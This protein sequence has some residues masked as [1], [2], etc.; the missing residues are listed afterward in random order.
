MNDTGV[1]PTSTSFQN[2]GINPRI[3]DIVTRMNFTS[4]TPIQHQAIPPALSGKDVVG[5]AQT[6]TG[7][8]LAF[9]IPMLQSILEKGGRGLVILPTRELAHQVDETLRKFGPALGIESAVFIG[10]A[11]MYQQKQMLKRN[12]KIL[13][14]TPG[15]LMDHLQ[16]GTVTLREVNILVLDEADRMFDMG[17]APA[18]QRIIKQIP[19]ERQTMLFSAT[20]PH[21]I[22][23]LA[24]AHMKMPL[25]IEVAPQG[26]T[27]DRVE[28]ELIMVRKEEKIRLLESILGTVKGT[29]LVFS[30]TKHGAKKIARSVK[31]MGHTVSELHANKSLN[32]RKEALEGFKRGRY[33]VLIATDIAAR[34]IDVKE[35]ELV[36]NYDLPDNPEDYVHRI[37]RTGRA[38]LAGRAVSFATPDQQGEIRSIERLVRTT[39]KRAALP[40][41]LPPP[42]R[43]EEPGVPAGRSNYVPRA[44][45]PRP[46][47]RQRRSVPPSHPRHQRGNVPER[48]GGG[49]ARGR[50]AFRSRVNPEKLGGMQ[51]Q[52]F[53]DPL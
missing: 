52:S 50:G 19:S 4:P 36:I 46:P 3:L 48:R 17:F 16:Q 30:R 43:V 40:S 13:V 38:G 21:A 34:G 23:Q 27:A 22:M 47:Q 53:Q 11:S 9:G 32:Q 2:L 24:G 29:V 31:S 33:R 51:E 35:I 12:P 7:K 42:R 1:T 49:F 8:T 15:R 14:A 28:Q 39:I 10:G 5:I 25:R 45:A 44:D 6:G 41:N 18:I 26:T 20:M 37:G